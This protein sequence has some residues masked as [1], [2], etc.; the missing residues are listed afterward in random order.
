MG[1][2]DYRNE[3]LDKLL[4]DER[5]VQWDARGLEASRIGNMDVVINMVRQFEHIDEMSKE[6]LMGWYN[7]LN[8]FPEQESLG[9]VELSGL[10]KAV[11]FWEA[12]PLAELKAECRKRK[13]RILSR[14]QVGDE[15]EQK[16]RLMEKLIM[17]MRL[18]MW[19]GQGFEARK[20]NSFDSVVAVVERYECFL[21][22]TDA[23]LR[24]TYSEAGLPVSER[25]GR[26]ELLQNLRTVLVWE[27]LPLH[28]LQQ[29]CAQRGLDS[30][31]RP[32]WGS[33]SRTGAN[34]GNDSERCF[35]LLRRLK[36]D[37]RLKQP[38][39]GSAEL[40]CPSSSGVDPQRVESLSSTSGDDLPP[41]LVNATSPGQP[42]LIPGQLALTATS[43]E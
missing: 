38:V 43:M 12:L 4:I 14:D 18:D 16:V 34:N 28:Q 26:E 6:D 19:E 29:E 30:S 8:M 36:G 17:D 5:M 32:R 33:A 1:T 35:E 41:P 7:G 13:L 25:V 2:E 20:L 22:A 39:L 37:L 21:R 11:T 9:E 15:S 23:E 24:M 31:T 40:Q 3:L 27:N 42:A 10:L